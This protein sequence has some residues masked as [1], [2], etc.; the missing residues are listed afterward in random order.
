VARRQER[1][2]YKSDNVLSMA[3]P[4]EALAVA[5]A[6]EEEGLGYR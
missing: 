1:N 6:R 2:D 5:V 4:G 3:Q